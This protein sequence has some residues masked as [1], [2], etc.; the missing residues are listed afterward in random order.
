MIFIVILL[1][2]IIIAI[3]SIHDQKRTDR[4]KEEDYEDYLDKTIRDTQW[5]FFAKRVVEENSHLDSL[6]D[7]NKEDRKWITRNKDVY[8][9]T[10]KHY[11]LP[12]IKRQFNIFTSTYGKPR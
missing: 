12:E 2:F 9:G 7:L 11:I 10:V 8:W 5:K 1:I 4:K 3:W 6:V